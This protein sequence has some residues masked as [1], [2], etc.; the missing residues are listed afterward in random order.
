M[1][2]YKNREVTFLSPIS[3]GH[4]AEHALVKHADGMTES[5]LIEGI[6]FTEEEKK[7][8]IKSYPSR[9]E[10]VKVVETEKKK[11]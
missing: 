1:A 4:Q 2:F 3:S 11:K 10:D 9:F 6:T 5:A 8:L 7:N